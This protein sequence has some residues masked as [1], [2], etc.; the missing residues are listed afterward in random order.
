[1]KC[2]SLKLANF[3]NIST[4][5]ISFDGQNFLVGDNGQGKTNV[6]ESL[7]YLSAGDSFRSSREAW[8]IKTGELFAR[9]EA[10]FELDNGNPRIVSVVL[11]RD[12]LGITK[13]FRLDNAKVS[14]ADFLGSF[15]MVLFAPENVSLMRLQSI[16]RRAF[17]NHIITKVDPTYYDDLMAY[18]KALRQRNQLLVQIRR[19]QAEVEE[20]SPWDDR[21]SALGSLIIKKRQALVDALGVWVG[22]VYSQVSGQH[23]SRFRVVYQ[24]DAGVITPEQYISRLIKSRDEDIRYGHTTFGPHRDDLVFLLN[25]L[26]AKQIASQ[27]EFRLMMVALKLAE[28][29]YI[30]KQLQ[31]QPI[32]LLDDIF[33][34]LDESNSRRVVEFLGDAQVVVTT[35]DRHK[36]SKGA[37]VLN[38]VAGEITSSVIP[39]KAGI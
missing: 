38:V 2:V 10:S 17:M 31:E 9:I 36:I 3:R 20:L 5:E 30:K 16:T 22:P 15:L 11:E 19:R 4:A 8:A 23:D 34:E 27:G 32:Y 6:L 7:Y 12:E 1:M 37:N 39:A 29:E 18:A 13:N 25:D 14:K 21:M 28:G 33:S 35:T 26:D 24:T